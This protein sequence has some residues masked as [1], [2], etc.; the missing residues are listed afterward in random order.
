MCL[1]R[2]AISAYTSLGV[3]SVRLLHCLLRNV[4][5]IL[6]PPPP[7]LSYLRPMIKVRTRRLPNTVL[8]PVWHKDRWH[9]ICTVLLNEREVTAENTGGGGGWMSESI[10]FRIPEVSPIVAHIHGFRQIRT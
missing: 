1:L 4:M 10:V 7:P 8:C 6:P 5:D 2:L 3:D 9:L